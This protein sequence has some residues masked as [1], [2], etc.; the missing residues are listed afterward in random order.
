[1]PRIFRPT[2]K[3]K[4]PSSNYR[5]RHQLVYNDSRWR[6]LREAVMQRD[7]GLCQECLQKGRLAPATQVHHKV[8]PFQIGLSDADFQYYAWSMENLEAICQE[9][10]A[11]IH[12]HEGQCA[13]D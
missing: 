6:P 5:R 8:S 9:C 2:P 12:A 3:P 11:A 4:K 7:G 1:M 10:H 13:K